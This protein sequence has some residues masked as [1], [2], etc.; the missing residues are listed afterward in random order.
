MY[1]NL[2]V[3]SGPENLEKMLRSSSRRSQF[4]LQ[5]DVLLEVLAN[6]INYFTPIYPIYKQ[7][8]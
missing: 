8:K 3:F 6:G 2:H 5:T 7:V 4:P 1:L